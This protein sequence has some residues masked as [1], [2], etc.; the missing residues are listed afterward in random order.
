[1]SSGIFILDE[2]LNPLILKNFKGLSDLPTLADIFKAA[3]QKTDRP[4]IQVKGV[5]FTYIRRDT[6][7]F[8]SITVGNLRFNVMSVLV[9]LDQFV[10]LLKK[11]LRTSTLDKTYVVDNFNII[12]ELLDESLDFGI[13]QLTDYNII[14]DSI[15]IEVNLP[16]EKYRAADE[17]L[18]S[19][20]DIEEIE[21]EI[22][23]K[24]QP[25]YHGFQDDEQYINSFILRATTQAIS[26]RPKGI[27]YAKNEFFVDV[28][29]SLEYVMDFNTSKIRKNFVHGRIKCRSFLSGMPKLKICINKMLREK[30]TFLESAKFH[31][32]VSLESLKS[33]EAINFVPPDGEFDLCQYTFKRHIN[34]SPSI[35][36]C[37]YKVNKRER[38]HKL[39]I[40]VTIEPHFKAQDSTS[41]LDI[42]VPLR[43][44]F[45]EYQIDLT[46]SPRFKCDA[47]EVMFNLSDDHLLWQI[48]SIKGGHG[49]QK[50]SM[51]V[52]F[53]LFDEEE[54]KKK[55]I[56]LET[57]MDPP[58]LREGPHLEE[59]YAQIHET[60]AFSK[61]HDLINI[62]F[63]IPYY[64][65]SGLKVEFL[66]IEEDQLKYQSFPWVRYKTI[67]D[68]EYAYQI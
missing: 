60:E 22:K 30:K 18:D 14:Q 1:M 20:S 49:E 13:P 44:I 48:G 63:E 26:W 24:T 46:K 67:N 34:D 39:H 7:Y 33:S 41:T 23:K 53:H 42:Q 11:Y 45:K 43:K 4:I 38:K 27:Y 61:T 12:Y 3:Q 58:P 54:H 65:C 25:D 8:V 5:V 47:G 28:I 2:L 6:L 40:T 36:L 64:T 35:K 15:K 10:I 68:D 57:S 62:K 32:C 16:S 55:I 29:E 56:E 66:K 59:L 19:D 17:Q 50:L 9:Y 51:H 37:D 21:K 31:Q 52:E